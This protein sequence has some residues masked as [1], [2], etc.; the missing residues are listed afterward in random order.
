MITRVFFLNRLEEGA[1]AE[2]YENHGVDVFRVENGDITV[3]H[4]NNDV[5]THRAAFARQ[6]S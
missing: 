2:D 4:E 1:A 5:V 6:A 3:V